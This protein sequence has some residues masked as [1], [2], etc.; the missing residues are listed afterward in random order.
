MN[1]E[2][3]WKSGLQ[4]AK[5]LSG[6]RL[7]IVFL[8]KKEPMSEKQLAGCM[9]ED[10]QGVAA[11]LC[12]LQA[13]GL[14]SAEKEGMAE[15]VVSAEK[16]GMAEIVVSAEKEGMAEIVVSADEKP[17]GLE[18]LSATVTSGM[19]QERAHRTG[20]V[21]FYLTELGEEL[22]PLCREL[23][24]FGRLY[25]A[26][27][28][29]VPELMG[30]SDIPWAEP[31]GTAAGSTGAGSPQNTE[32]DF[33]NLPAKKVSAKDRHGFY[34]AYNAFVFFNPHCEFENWYFYGETAGK[35]TEL[36]LITEPEYQLFL[37]ALKNAGPAPKDQAMLKL[38]FSQKTA[39]LN[40][41]KETAYQL[42]EDTL[43]GI[44]VPM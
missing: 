19:F 43:I 6:S 28:D 11:E 35:M 30:G 10:E 17:G 4:A 21:R 24:R 14:V 13:V 36:Y 33:N 39:D 15:I 32:D 37:E 5:L 31:D 7:Q 38:R 34:Q 40:W 16:E 27:K 44:A 9:E 8:L 3:V 29:L 41:E 1:T 20:D 25:E 23:D 2:N 18:D 26:A 22:L 12:V 42:A